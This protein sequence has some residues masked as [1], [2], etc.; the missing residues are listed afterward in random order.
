VMADDRCSQTQR[1]AAKAQL[2]RV[3]L[4]SYLRMPASIASYSRRR[5]RRS[6]AMFDCEDGEAG[7]RSEGDSGATD[8]VDGG[9]RPDFAGVGEESRRAG[10]TS[11]LIEAERW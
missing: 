2:L 7:A 3:I 6:G 4:D 9:R 10:I 11:L 1:P 8:L 5:T